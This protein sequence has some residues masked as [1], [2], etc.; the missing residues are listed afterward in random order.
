[1]LR[2][3]IT[4]KTHQ[5]YRYT[6]SIHRAIVGALAAAGATTDEL[7]GMGA[8]PWT[9]AAQG[10][11]LHGERSVLR[12][13]TISTSDSR[14]SEILEKIDAAKI[15]SGLTNG[16]IV[17]CAGASVSFLTARGLPIHD[18]LAV[19]FASPFIVSK[20]KETKSA[21]EHLTS[22]KDAD[23]SAAFSYGLSRRIGRPIELRVT[24]DRL[25]LATYGDSPRRVNVRKARGKTVFLPAF[26]IP[27]TLEGPDRDIAAAF[28]AGLG[29]KTRYGFGCPCLPF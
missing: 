16:D 28:F 9:F 23:L 20:R 29:E 14:L 7:V 22:L 11:G 18:A 12:Y 15:V 8:K 2:A 1:M 4:L 3:E 5:V 25:S 10:E 27:L 6:D 13:L 17:D 26:Q 19:N 21:T 24:V